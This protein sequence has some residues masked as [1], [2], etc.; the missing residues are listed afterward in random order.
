VNP[1]VLRRPLIV[2]GS[3]VLMIA[4]LSGA[5][6][7][8]LAETQLP[9]VASLQDPSQA[10]F[11]GCDPPQGWLRIAVEPG[12]TLED[13]ATAVSLPV[14]AIRT[15]NCEIEQVS[16][17]DE[18]YLPR[19]PQR[20][21]FTPCGPPPGWTLYLIPEGE[22]WD[23]LA[24]QFNASATALQMA[25]CLDPAAALISGE[26]LYMP[27]DP[28]E[29]PL[30]TSTPLTEIAATPADGTIVAQPTVTPGE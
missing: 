30:M 12:E 26:K 13:L 7:T 5:F 10:Q 23:G 18:I 3:G 16:A 1:Q 4:I 20:S 27:A 21:I 15:A 14:D 2:L 19:R 28:E 25:N 17:G 29:M 6:L 24:Q 9:G 11:T 22:T 8:A